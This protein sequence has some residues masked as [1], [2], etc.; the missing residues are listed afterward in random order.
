MLY[1]LAALA[2]S[3]A[4]F[5]YLVLERQGP[6]GIPLALLRAVAWGLVAALLLNPAVRR[7]GA[8]RPTVLLD[9]SLSMSDPLPG[10]EGR[11]QAALDSARRFEGARLITFGE[12][13]RP[14][15][16]GMRP[17]AT[18]SRLL[19]ALRE[20]AA[21][22]G[23]VVVVT[24]GAIDDA[25]AVPTDLLRRARVIVVPGPDVRDAGVAGFDLP[26]ALRGGDTARVAV[27][28]AWRAGR[29]RDTALVEL[30]EADRVVA[31]ARLSLG[32][33]GVRRVE[34]AFVPAPPRGE[35]EVRRY[36]ARLAGFTDDGEPRDD[37]RASAAVVT[38]GAAVALLSDSPDW[39]FRWLVQTLAATSG[40]PVRAFVKATRAAD[41]WRDA[42]SLRPVP[43]AE[44]RR[45]AARATLLVLHGT[46]AG[47]TP[48]RPLRS[49]ALLEWP[50]ATAAGEWYV[51][52]PELATP[53][54]GALGGMA[55]ES[56]P[57]LEAV[58]TVS[59]DSAAWTGLV[60]SQDRRGRP[61]P[62]VQG[63]A[64]GGRRTVTVAG[65]GFWRWAGRGGAA[66]E[67][68][69]ALVASLAD[70]LLEERARPPVQLLALRDSLSR[71]AAEF[72]PRRAVL[73]AQPGIAAGGPGEPVPL[74]HGG[75]V[76][77]VAIV[78]LVA[79]WIARRRRGLR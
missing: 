52:A 41:G 77:M 33:G 57:P 73:A 62:V 70:W 49:G 14:Y 64:R 2:A 8:P 39:D 31:R 12:E 9:A 17:A 5:L 72:L 23:P 71:G 16:E 36:E 53:V 76:Y 54:G 38:R 43:E 4:L 56:L 60:A 24:D 26:A 44:L 68:Y 30:R 42:R 15:V 29:P 40:V 11:W 34:L 69:R 7:L 32:E 45:E 55:P 50:V 61:R 25:G 59:A 18:A 6:S 65:S 51:A 27:D 21:R 37:A 66:A 35:G 47:M 58:A 19:P 63:L 22:G 67:A 10:G 48:F 28:V 3:A 20:A 13:P 1:F 78:A 46:A 79:E 74:R 75:W